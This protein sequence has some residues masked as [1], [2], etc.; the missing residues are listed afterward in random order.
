[1]HV[2]LCYTGKST[3]LDIISGRQKTGTVTGQ[4]L[5]DGCAKTASDM[6]K[7]C[8]YVMQDDALLPQ[9]TVRETL[10]Y[11]ARLRGSATQ[12]TANLS[13]A[14]AAAQ[15][16]AL[17]SSILHVLNLNRVADTRVGSQLQRGISG[18]LRAF[19]FHLLYK[20]AN[21]QTC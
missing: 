1:M 7:L 6:T 2:F 20:S 15:R 10:E 4:I 13:A 16:S 12:S 11:S 9:L 3:L 14:E 21:S 8:G 18:L 5:V 19:L 17:V